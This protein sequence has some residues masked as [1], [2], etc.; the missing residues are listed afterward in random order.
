M[1]NRFLNYFS[2]H[3]LFQK[4]DTIFGL[5][6][7]VLLLHRKIC[8]LNLILSHLRSSKINAK[9]IFSL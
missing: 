3:S 6:D 5:I 2:W 7:R 9:T 1:D 4:L 8:I